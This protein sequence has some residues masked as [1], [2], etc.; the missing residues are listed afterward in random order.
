MYEVHTQ[1]LSA[2]EK[3]EEDEVTSSTPRHVL[4]SILPAR[5]YS[6]AR[7]SLRLW[8]LGMAL[9]WLYGP[10]ESRSNSIP[11]DVSHRQP[12]GVGE[13]RSLEAEE[14]CSQP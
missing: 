7:G 12:H 8:G 3:G 9:S 5:R 6:F 13:P 4:V 14:V 11:T 2:L 10:R 1:L